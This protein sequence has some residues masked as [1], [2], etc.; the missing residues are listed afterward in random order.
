[1]WD[2]RALKVCLRA[3]FRASSS[4]SAFLCLHTSFFLSSLIVFLHQNT[5]SV[6]GVGDGI[7]SMAVHPHLPILA[8]GS[9]GQV[10]Y[11]FAF[12]SKRT[13]FIQFN[14][15]CPHVLGIDRGF[16]SSD[17][18][19][20]TQTRSISILTAQMLLWLKFKYLTAC[21]IGITMGF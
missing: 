21:F 2:M 20:C 13:R 16:S 6:S 5:I 4:V 10:R 8:V 9:M 7:T 14:A 19:R 15:G 11:S 3:A 12:N 18:V 1:M 17:S